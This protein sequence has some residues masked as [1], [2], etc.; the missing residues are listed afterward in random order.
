MERC[1][2]GFA[3]VEAYTLPCT[4]CQRPLA[5]PGAWACY[6][7]A[8]TGR[9]LAPTTLRAQNCPHCGGKGRMPDP[10]RRAVFEVE[11]RRLLRAGSSA[12]EVWCV[13]NALNPQAVRTALAT[14]RS[15]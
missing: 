6:G 14:E 13:Q 12:F 5:E 4:A 2:L 1:S 11:A 7:Q 15:S 3:V 10:G 8:G 9:A